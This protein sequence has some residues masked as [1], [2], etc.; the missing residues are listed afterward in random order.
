LGR[1]LSSQTFCKYDALE[2]P[3]PPPSPTTPNGAFSYEKKAYEKK[4]PPGTDKE[5]ALITDRRTFFRE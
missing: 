4:L 5:K 3:S 2:V 1:I